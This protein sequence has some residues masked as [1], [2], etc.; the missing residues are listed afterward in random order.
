MN[1]IILKGKISSDIDI[2]FT[3]TTNKEIS[4]FS[5]AVRRDYKNQSGEYESD[6]FN[7]TAFENTAK[8]VSQYFS[9]GQEILLMG[10]LQNRS[11]ETESGEKRH[12]TDVIVDT[13]EFCGSKKQENNSNNF[14]Q[15]MSNA[16][17]EFTTTSVDNVSGNLS[18]NSD[19][20]PF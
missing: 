11:W 20:L 8:F 1:K 19:D 13:I 4:R 16:N 12:A 7:C 5:I 6:F 18:L 2:K 10:H 9:K 15:A 14:E 17:M 3:Q